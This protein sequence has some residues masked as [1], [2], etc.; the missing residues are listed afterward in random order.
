MMSLKESLNRR[1]PLDSNSSAVSSQRSASNK[2]LECEVDSVG[3]GNYDGG[4]D[5]ATADNEG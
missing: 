4:D 5:P 3:D 2:H 1:F